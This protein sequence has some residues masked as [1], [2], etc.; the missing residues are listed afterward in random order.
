MPAYKVVLRRRW[1]GEELEQKI[2]EYGHLPEKE[3][4][5]RLAQRHRL[6]AGATLFVMPLKGKGPHREYK[7]RD[8]TEQ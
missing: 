7:V 8:L 1:F 6:G 4:L 3:D 2:A 5:L